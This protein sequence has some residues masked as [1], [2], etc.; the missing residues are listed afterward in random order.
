MPNIF[1]LA[2]GTDGGATVGKGLANALGAYMMGDKS[3][4]V[5]RDDAYSKQIRAWAAEQRGRK[6]QLEADDLDLNG[7]YRS[8]AIETLLG[9]DRS[10]PDYA[11]TK[12]LAEGGPK[13]VQGLTKGMVDSLDLARRTQAAQAVE[14]LPDT[15]PQ[16]HYFQA[17][18]D[19][20]G[21]H[22]G[23][24]TKGM[25]QAIG[26][27]QRQLALDTLLQA[28]RGGELNL[29]LLNTMVSAA[30]GKVYSPFRSV[31]STGASIDEGTGQMITGSPDLFGLHRGEVQSRIR[32]NNAQ[33]GNTNA[34]AQR[35]RAAL[36]MDGGKPLTPK[37]LQ[38]NAR[39]DEAR[40]FVD[41][42]SAAQKKEVMSV[43]SI[44]HNAQQRLIFNQIQLAGKPKYGD[45]DS[46]ERYTTELLIDPQKLTAVKTLLG[47][48]P[49][50]IDETRS[51]F[52][53]L[54]WTSDRPMTPQEQR[55]WLAQQS[56]LT[57]AEVDPYIGAAQREPQAPGAPLVPQSAPRPVSMYRS[58]EAVRQ[59]YRQGIIS[60]EQAK[61]ELAAFGM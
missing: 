15:D 16:R 34:S 59:A 11:Y 46:P 60:R 45:A 32:E 22:I 1:K 4:Q 33:A 43:P 24:A 56:G 25:G 27:D 40:K 48:M 30:E 5:A 55:Q 42:L 3:Q 10:N 14:A 37:Q 26:V 39:I 2:V 13:N 21:G 50:G 35:H 12:A 41:T 36:G 54:S 18:A 6:S 29:P 52:N 31:G 8:R 28:T 49:N 38:D 7:Q 57:S 20:G 19:V 47:D 23:D 44:S 51:V 61:Q 17:L 9:L 53:P 58:A